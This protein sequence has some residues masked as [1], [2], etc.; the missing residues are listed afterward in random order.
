MEDVRVWE[1]KVFDLRQLLEISRALNSTLDYHYLIQAVLDICLAQA[2]TLKAG[3]FLTPDID[4]DLLLPVSTSRELD[5]G[6]L[7]MFP[8]ISRE[9]PLVKH[10]E[11]KSQIL[12]VQEIKK[13]F[14]EE[15]LSKVL[16]R[17]NIEL[18]VGMISR[19][20]VIGIIFI[21]EKITGQE[22]SQE[23]YSFLGDL[24]TLS[25]IAVTNARLYDRATID[26]MTGLKNHAYFNSALKEER[27]KAYKKKGT[28]SLLFADIDHFKKFNDNY[29]HQ[30]GDLVLRSVANELLSSIRKSD[31]AAR[32]G[33]EEFCIIMPG[34][35]KV[36]A[37]QFAERLRKKIEATKVSLGKIDLKIS[38][39]IGVAELDA[40]LDLKNNKSIIER[41]DKAL[42]IGKKNGR[43]Q[44][45]I[46]N[47]NL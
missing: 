28:L 7:S 27:E 34:A 40:T 11:E 4:A 32:Y 17:L 24:A 42:Y 33:G 26:I 6:D 3:L 30:A 29:G 46:Y 13:L 2:Q 21:G 39:T 9:S 22:F 45:Q 16:F 23:E 36:S 19:G 31:V 5:A 18:L 37:G 41:A 1:K 20:R 35:N 44:V 25:A 47:E 43:N 38:I 10:I 15:S 12:T 8:E 14:P